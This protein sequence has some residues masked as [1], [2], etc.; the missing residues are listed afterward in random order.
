MCSNLSSWAS[1]KKEQVLDEDDK[2]LQDLKAWG[3]CS[4]WVCWRMRRS[5]A[6]SRSG[7]F[8]RHVAAS[9]QRCR[10]RAGRRLGVG[11]GQ[12]G[13]DRGGEPPGRRRSGQRR[14][15]GERKEEA[16][17]NSE[18]AHHLEVGR[19]ARRERRSWSAHWRR[20][21]RMRRTRCARTWRSRSGSGRG[22]RGRG[23]RS[24]A[25]RGWSGVRRAA[26]QKKR[27]GRR[28]RRVGVEH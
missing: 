4:L 22:R 16:E 2:C 7:R 17:R 3:T 10:G 12:Q 21:M 9:A 24:R 19:R 1:D 18:K 6:C 20:R 26:G 25:D 23:G 5:R 28:S 14:A 8:R 27:G 15:P 11:R 13:C